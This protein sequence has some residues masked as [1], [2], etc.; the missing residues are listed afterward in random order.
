MATTGFVNIVNSTGSLSV[1]IPSASKGGYTISMYE[2]ATSTIELAKSEKIYINGAIPVVPYVL[3]TNLSKVSNSTTY[4]SLKEQDII[5]TCSIIG[6]PSGVYSVPYTITFDSSNTDHPS[7][8]TAADIGLSSLQGV[9]NVDYSNVSSSIDGKLTLRIPQNSTGNPYG[10][11]DY[12]KIKLNN[13]SQS[14][15]L[16]YPRDGTVVVSLTKDASTISKGFSSKITL[17]ANKEN[18]SLVPYTII[19][20]LDTDIDVPLTGNFT[21]NNNTSSITITALDNV[22][23]TL[24]LSLD[25]FSNVYVSLT[26]KAIAAVP[27]GNVISLLN[28]TD[29]TDTVKFTNFSSIGDSYFTPSKS[30]LNLSSTSL[31]V[32]NTIIGATASY[33]AAMDLSLSIEGRE[34]LPNTYIEIKLNNSGSVLTPVYTWT[35]STLL[36]NLES[37]ALSLVSSINA[38]TT[39]GYI[40]TYLSTIG[41]TSTIRIVRPNYFFLDKF[42]VNAFA[43]FYNFYVDTSEIAF[44]TSELVSSNDIGKYLELITPPETSTGGDYKPNPYTGNTGIWTI[45]SVVGRYVVLKD[46]QAKPDLIPTQYGAYLIFGTYQVL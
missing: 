10:C 27:D 18:G 4:V 45:K 42:S 23:K 34:I 39:S 11:E 44:I 40:A 3:S 41:T 26:L 35:A 6:K 24:V 2:T 7:N 38:D 15:S 37:A 43:A 20:A 21:V 36:P 19:D 33:C 12:I 46:R 32:P 16:L 31:V 25:D 17:T 30:I 22:D 14:I 28:H 1:P 5:I 8:L 9:F 13:S 29:Y